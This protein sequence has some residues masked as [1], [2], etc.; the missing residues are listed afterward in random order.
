MFV[1][2]SHSQKKKPC[3][4]FLRD[5]LARSMRILFRRSLLS[6][7][8]SKLASSCFSVN[9]AIATY[10]RNVFCLIFLSVS[11]DL[12]FAMPCATHEGEVLTPTDSHHTNSPSHRDTYFC[13]MVA[14]KQN[15]DAKGLTYLQK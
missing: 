2:Q 10:H 14:R 9:E 5:T 6:F 3:I 7:L 8:L 13:N 1:P 11:T 4:F 12:N 15:S